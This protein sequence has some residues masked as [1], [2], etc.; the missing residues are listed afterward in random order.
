VPGALLEA[1]KPQ[2]ISDYL[3]KLIDHVA[4]DGGQVLA[5]GAVLDDSMHTM[6]DTG[7]EYGKYQNNSL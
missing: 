1:G 5:N 3:K 2:E 7:K 6:F 4:R